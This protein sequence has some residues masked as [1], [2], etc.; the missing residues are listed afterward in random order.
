[1][2]KLLRT[3]KIF[4]CNVSYFSSLVWCCEHAPHNY[5]GT[6]KTVVNNMVLGGI[7]AR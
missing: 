2:F 5:C 3:A 6:R 7:I 4:F 1:M